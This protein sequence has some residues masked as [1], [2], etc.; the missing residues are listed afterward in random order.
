MWPQSTNTGLSAIHDGLSPWIESSGV[1]NEPL[2]A[3]FAI[4]LAGLATL[5]YVGVLALQGALAR[6]RHK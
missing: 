4:V 2:L 6:A 3:I 1:P 5:A